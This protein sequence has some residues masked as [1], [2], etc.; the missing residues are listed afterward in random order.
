M[1]HA[2]ESVPGGGGDAELS[3]ALRASDADRERIAE[4]I[5][6]AA[7]EGRISYQELDERL[8]SAIGA[9]TLGELERLVADLPPTGAAPAPGAVDVRGAAAAGGGSR[10]T[11]ALMGGSHR[12]GSWRLRARHTV[13]SVMG[14][15]HLDLR[16]AQFSDQVTTMNVLALMGGVHITVPAGMRVEVS[17]IALMG[18]THVRLGDEM[19]PADA[20]LLRVR[21]L[22]LMGGVTVRGGAGEPALEGEAGLPRL[23]GSG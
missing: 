21:A 8:A 5:R 1:S 23:P 12:R 18:G 13:L 15:A 10:L 14:G 4:R 20:P 6:A 9:V 2:A 17:R 22:A 3:P 19:P 7:T 16:R 11:L